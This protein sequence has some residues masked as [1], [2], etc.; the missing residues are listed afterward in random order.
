[1]LQ[2]SAGRCLRC[3]RKAR[4]LWVSMR[5]SLDIYSSGG[6][7]EL[8]GSPSAYDYDANHR[9]TKS[10]GIATYTWDAD[11]NL[12]TRSDGTTFTHDALSR[13]TG[14]AK[15]GTTASYAHDPFGRRIRKTV[16]YTTWY[17][18]NGDRLLA[19]YD[20]SGNRTVRYAYAE[21]WTPLQ[22]EIGGPTGTLYDVHTDHLG[23]PRRM[24]NA[25]QA[26]A[27]RAK[28]EVFGKA[29]TTGSATLNLRFPGQHFDAESGLHYN[30]HRTYD[31][32][33]GRYLEQDPV[34][35]FGSLERAGLWGGAV[36]PG[37]S[38][39][40]GSLARAH[41]YPY[42]GSNPL[43]LIDPTGECPWCLAA[44]VGFVT[45]FAID[46]AVQL[47]SNGW[48]VNC[49][50]YGS[51]AIAGGFG[52][53]GGA[54]GL[55]GKG[56]AGFEFS[57]FIPAR[58]ANRGVPSFLVNSTLNGNAVPWWFHAAT[59]AYRYRFVPAASKP[60]IWRLL[61]PFAQAARVPGWLG[62]SAAGVAATSPDCGCQ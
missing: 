13:L 43:S 47:A 4:C 56:A 11:G 34:G 49:L 52:A 61:T 60:F 46:L 28:Y 6:N 14:Y 12:A 58:F 42:A 17:L 33:A 30:R 7:R 24:T 59:D 25:S 37:G 21:G 18:W 50:D 40:D 19:E 16:N 32:A 55:L 22:V 54:V 57:H 29:T 8:P 39:V 9:L 45:G 10:P 53:L 31:P 41:L 20:G 23:T 26:T 48:N 15:S 62:G 36:A 5:P 2:Q 38:A 44:G 27:W 35:Q 51:A 1:M 3:R